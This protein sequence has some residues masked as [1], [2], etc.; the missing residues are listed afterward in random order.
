MNVFHTRVAPRSAARIRN[1]IHYIRELLALATPL[2]ISSTASCLTFSGISPCTCPLRYFTVLLFTSSR[3]CSNQTWAQTASALI[4]FNCICQSGSV[5]GSLEL[6]SLWAGRRMKTMILLTAASEPHLCAA[7]S[8]LGLDGSLFCVSPLQCTLRFMMSACGRAEPCSSGW[9]LKF[10]QLP[11]PSAERAFLQA[12]RRKAS[13]SGRPCLSKPFLFL[14]YHS[15]WSFLSLCTI[16]RRFLG[17]WRSQSLNR[18]LVFPDLSQ[19]NQTRCWSLWALV[20]TEKLIFSRFG[21]CGGK[22][23]PSATIPCSCVPWALSWCFNLPLNPFI[24]C[25]SIC[26]IFC[27]KT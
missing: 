5:N 16:L 22:P 8:L 11:T 19:R 12:E 20:P 14:T 9:H 25:I 27:D 18:A 13:A 6:V 4:R 1:V 3:F 17:L 10:F 2:I 7:S 15:S 26:V 24:C 23:L 21:S